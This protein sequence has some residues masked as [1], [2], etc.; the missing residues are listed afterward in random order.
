MTCLNMNDLG[1]I[2]D[3]ALSVDVNI[4]KFTVELG[5]D[6]IVTV[7]RDHPDSDRYIVIDDQVE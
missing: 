2:L 6:K 7:F 1:R 5:D 4:S 3:T